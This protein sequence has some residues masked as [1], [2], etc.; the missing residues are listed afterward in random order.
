[1]SEPGALRLGRGRVVAFT[2]V[3]VLVIAGAGTYVLREARRS[4]AGLAAAA[5]SESAAPKLDA[6]T[7]LRQPHLVFRN[8]ALGPSNGKIAVVPLSSPGGPR[9]TVEVP[10]ER[11]YA[12]TG[13]GFCLAA[14]RGV[15]T[16]Y[17]GTLLGPDLRPVR[18]T[19]IVGGPS[20]AR[21]SADAKR[22]ASTVFVAGHSYLDV[23]F[24]TVTE[25][26]DTTTGKGFGN[27]ETYRIV[28]DGRDYHSQ[29]V[30][31]WGVTFASDDVFYA[32]LGTRGTTYLVRGS[33][34]GKQVTVLRDNVE[35]PSLSPDGKRIA[36]KKAT[37]VSAA[38]KWRFTVLD[39]A[40]GVE[41]PLP[42][43][44]SVD[45][46]IDWMDDTHV[47]YG[48]PRGESGRTD[49]WMSPLAGGAPALLVPD[50]DSPSVVRP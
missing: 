35:C 39:L 42:E 49:I 1:M 13:G 6:A 25:I 27:L 40:S 18:D 9:A 50:A 11:V 17:Q 43:T 28:K 23:G 5:A 22:A 29:D 32:T 45:D 38:R 19:R 33:V 31:F 24:S 41:T 3:A 8:T 20:R 48:V 14:H 2:V 7:V 26:V 16:T 10:C 47:L 34:S 21:L 46:Q 36:F 30:N 44:R 12:V 4:D 15:V 37:G